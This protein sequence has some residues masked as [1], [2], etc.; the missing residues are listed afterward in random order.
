MTRLTNPQ[1]LD[2]G[3][4]DW[5]ALLHHLSARF[6]T[7][8]FE[9]GAELVAA[10][11]R[12]ADEAGHHPDVT[13]TYP[14]VAVLLTTHDEGGV[15]DKDI[16]MA[17]VISALAD[18][19]GVLADP[20]STQAVELALDT[21]DQ[22][23]IGE[24]WS[25]VLTGDPDNYVDDT[26]VDPL[27]RCP[28]LWFQDSEP[29]DTPHQRFHLDITI[30]PEALEPRTEAALAAGG[31]VAWETPTF[32]VLED[33]QGNRACLCWSEGRNQDS[34]PTHAAHALID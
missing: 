19:R 21:P 33:V 25:V 17:R 24:F 15:T 29:H 23:A 4:N 5:R 1:I 18:E 30:P 8:D 9:T 11:A 28:D 22:A 12:A 14:S 27:G 13:L 2:A 16:E 31:R 20:A 3:L 32:R 26:V 6:L 34:E 10:I 7:V